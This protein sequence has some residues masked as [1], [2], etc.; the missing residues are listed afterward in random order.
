[1]DQY[2]FYKKC[3]ITFFFVFKREVLVTEYKVQT[4]DMNYK[5][6]TKEHDEMYNFM[7]QKGK[8]NSSYISYY[9]SFDLSLF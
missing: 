6:T 4:D 8:S 1:M 9:W 3:K 7:S 5:T 2:S